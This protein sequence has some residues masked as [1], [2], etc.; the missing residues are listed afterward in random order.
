MK[1]NHHEPIMT[2]GIM[3]KKMTILI[4]LSSLIGC[5]NY[6]TEKYIDQE[7]KAINEIIP[8]MIKYH[9]MVKMNNLDTLNLRLFLISTL[10]TQICEINKPDGFV[11]SENGVKLPN[12]EIKEGQKEYEENIEKYKLEMRLFSALR[13]GTLNKRVLD[14]KFE[15]LTLK[16]E[17]IPEQNL[18]YKLKQN[19]FGYL[20]VSRIILNRK[21]DKGYL[22]FS[23]YC[24]EGCYW[25]TMF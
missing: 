7:N 8:Q 18:D 11:I 23:F 22:S 6:E 2:T 9:E 13:N 15:Y 16:I 12:E 25:V 21:Y 17:L 19:E 10:D 3:I 20:K 14:Y 24:G 5:M 1:N 4:L